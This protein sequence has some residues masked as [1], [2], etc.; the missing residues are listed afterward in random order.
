MAGM[1][2]KAAMELDWKHY[3][4]ESSEEIKVFATLFP[5]VSDFSQQRK[6]LGADYH[7]TNALWS[8]AD[9]PN[10]LNSRVDG[11]FEE[12]VTRSRLHVSIRLW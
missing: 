8:S 3:E 11:T 2:G 4:T 6:L 12:L 7:R 5:M 1:I 9:A 10:T